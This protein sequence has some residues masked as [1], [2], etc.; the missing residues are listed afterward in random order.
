M[1]GTH[2]HPLAFALCTVFTRCFQGVWR[3]AAS[4]GEAEGPQPNSAP[5]EPPPS[6]PSPEAQPAPKAAP[7]LALPAA[8]HAPCMAAPRPP[9]SWPWL[10]PSRAAAAGEEPSP[11]RANPPPARLPAVGKEAGLPLTPPL[12]ALFAARKGGDWWRMGANRRRDQDSGVPPCS[13][14]AWCGACLGS[15]PVRS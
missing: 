1:I 10:P 14:A 13:G 11:P 4:G 15:R 12:P 3:D 2:K 6:R 5:T 9:F 7:Q 8:P